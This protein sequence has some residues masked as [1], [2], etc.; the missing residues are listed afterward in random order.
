MKIYRGISVEA[1][2]CKTGCLKAGEISIVALILFKVFERD[3]IARLIELKRRMPVA[4]PR[5][6]NVHL[7]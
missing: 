3:R 2:S 7:A 1:T 4:D 5:Y 6:V